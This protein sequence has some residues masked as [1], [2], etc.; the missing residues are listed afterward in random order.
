M[1]AIF[2]AQTV[3]VVATGQPTLIIGQLPSGGGGVI[4]NVGGLDKAGKTAGPDDAWLFF[5]LAND[6]PAATPTPYGAA[7]LLLSGDSFN[8]NAD[9]GNIYALAVTTTT[10]LTVAYGAH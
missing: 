3:A 2:A 9:L 8:F 5:T 6:S 1:A 7:M 10:T 4:K